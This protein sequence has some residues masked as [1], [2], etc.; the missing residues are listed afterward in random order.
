[1]ISLNHTDLNDHL[2]LLQTNDL[3]LL[4]LVVPSLSAC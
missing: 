2:S 1:M 4:Q 3:L